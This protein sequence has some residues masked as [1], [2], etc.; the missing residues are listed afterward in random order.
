MAHREWNYLNNYKSVSPKDHSCEIWL[1]LAQW[2]RRCQML[3][4]H[5]QRQA[6]DGGRTTD[7][8]PFKIAHLEY[9]VS[10]ELKNMLST[11]F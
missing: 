5:G 7:S 10:G 9:H 8:W 4:D 11:V 3:T 6:D 1:K 2:F